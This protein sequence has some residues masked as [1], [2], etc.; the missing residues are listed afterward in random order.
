MTNGAKTMDTLPLRLGLTMWSHS[1]WQ[2]Q[3]YG[4]GTKPAE[5]LEKYTQ[6]FHTVEGNTTFYATP[7][8][9]T[10]HN[11]KAAS[12]DDFKFTFKLPKFITHQQH[13]K[14]C[15]AELKEFLLTMSPLH[16]RIGQWTIQLPH[17][18]EPSMLPALQKFCTLFPKDMQLGVEVRHLGFFDKGDAEKRF[19]HWLIEEGI[20]RI[21]MDSRPVFSAPPTTEAVI[22]AHQ[23]KPRVP[24]H[25]IATA[26][27]PMVRFIG[28][29][30]KEPNLAFFKPWFAKL[31]TWLNEGKQ[32]Y[33]MIHT[34]DNNHAPEL[35][36]AIYKQLQTQVAEHT[37]I[38]LPNLAEFPAQKGDHQISMF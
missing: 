32:P 19:N 17:S 35:A 2:S 28:H 1:E 30:D 14:H 16:R 36:I 23:K 5:R 20:N 29:P 12:H 33:L 27:N 15:Q 26:N 22:D 10:V 8:M 3:F 4:K 6:V 25:A 13:L 24:V 34:P 31:Q 9:S 38:T 7:S 37:K 21:I 11:W 18:F